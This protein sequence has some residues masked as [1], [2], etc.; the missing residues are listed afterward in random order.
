M[1]KHVFAKF[2][3]AISGAALLAA[4]CAFPAN[5]DP[6]ST[7]QFG[8]LVGFGSDTTMDVMDGISAALGTNP[9]GTLKLASYKAIGSAD[10]VTVAGGTAVPRA[11][12]SGAGKTLLEI[13]IG[14]KASGT[15]AIAPNELGAAR[16]AVVPT[17]SQVAGKIHFARSSSGPSG[18]VANGA[19]TFV[20]FGYDNMSYATSPDSLIPSD[21]PLGSAAN[22]TELSLT[23][24]YKGNLTKVITDETT[25]A[26]IKIEGPSYTPAAGEVANTI[27]AYIPQAGSGTRSFWIGRVNI[28]EANITAGTT[29]AKDVTPSGLSVQEH[30]GAALAGDK[31]ALVGFSIAQWVAQTNGVAPKRLSGAVLRTMGGVSPTV[32]TAGVY[33][34]N[35]AWTA[36]KRTVYNIVPTALANSET[37]NA[38]TRAFV[39]T[40][41]LVC[42]A[43]DVIQRYGYGLLSYEGVDAT[44]GQTS[45]GQAT[46][47]GNITAANRVSAPSASTVTLGAPVVS[48]SGSS[49]KILATVAS[50]GNQGGVVNLYSGFNTAN[51]E[52][53]ATGTVAKGATTVDIEIVN[54][55]STALSK[56]LTAQ[57]VPALS[58]VDAS[59]STVDGA[60]VSLKAATSV[61]FG[62]VTEAASGLSAS[63]TATVTGGQAGSLKIYAAG[64]DGAVLKTVD[65]PASGTATVTIDNANGQAATLALHGEFVPTDATVFGSSRTSASTA[66]TFPKVVSPTAKTA[67]SVSFGTVTRAANGLSGTFTATVTGGQAGSLKIYANGFDS[68]VIK[69][70]AVAASGSASVMIDDANGAAASYNLSGEFV[71]TDSTNYASSR[72]SASVSLSLVSVV[73]A[74]A[75]IATTVKKT[76][77][78]KVTVSIKN[79]KSTGTVGATGSIIAVVYNAK[80]VPVAV[81][82]AHVKLVNGSAS[83]TFAKIATLGKYTVKVFYGG[84]STNPASVIT[85][86]FTVVK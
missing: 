7:T 13:A 19:V 34:T 20:P 46:I 58:G 44:I 56:T 78:P 22:T 82:P 42:Q 86:T 76:V 84:N 37:P 68:A 2:A 61:S 8:E 12:G 45:G 31:F 79:N 51:Q 50:N 70:V 81:S 40:D 21:I 27:R 59:N 43:K 6:A 17:T 24:I 49:A 57:F 55:G 80:N 16:T 11:N 47:C 14:Q 15:V 53:V 23:N 38:I 26:Y 77:A 4:G 62:A 85:K 39:G 67:T 54:T 71:P 52:L 66:V 69:T 10:A 18:A 83:V 5:A 29:A 30:D 63:F 9:D 60:S 1:N 41:S 74:T 33:S 28:T 64:F 25:G 3:A 73:T 36:V 32:E 35:P 72:T 65:V 48:A 75:T